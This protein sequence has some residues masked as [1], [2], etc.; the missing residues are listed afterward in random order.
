MTNPDRSAALKALL[1]GPK[2]ARLLAVLN[3]DGEETRII[4]G[5]VRNTLLDVPVS[6]IDLATTALPEEVMR[7]AR[8]A[9]F[10]PVPTGIEHGTI[11]VVV[12]GTPFEVTSLREDIETDGRRASVRFGRD[13]VADALRRD[14]TVNALALNAEGEVLDYCGGLADLAARRIR[15]IGAPEARIREDY[16]RILRFFRFQAQYGRGEPDAAGLSACIALRAG[17]DG[18]SRERVQ[19]ELMKL[20][21]APLRNATVVSLAETGI[22]AHL[23]RGIAR[24][25]R[26]AGL[27]DNR[28]P[29][30]AL[31]ALELGKVEDATRLA[32]VLRL[33]NEAGRR[34]LLIAQALE[35]LGNIAD[36]VM[37]R[38]IRGLAFRHGRE[39]VADALYAVGSRFAASRNSLAQAAH[40]VPDSPFRG[41]DVVA[42]GIL[43]GPRV[44]AVIRAAEEAWIAADFPV[45]GE[46]LKAIISRSI[47]SV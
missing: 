18:L 35:A 11:T 40:A 1:A 46:A 31:A 24:I 2:L 38:T 29:V 41:A 20:L 43:A 17:L 8:L 3:Q 47:A 32:E 13:F 5:A 21:A 36:P 28:D 37:A 23:T 19:A 15:F 45:D 10:R 12:D 27:G 42:A 44:G 30:L 9:S 39:A 22:W 6:D 34:L 4:G 7:R 16:L 14:F 33:S 26:L 25:G